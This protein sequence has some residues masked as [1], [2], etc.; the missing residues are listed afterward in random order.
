MSAAEMMTAPAEAPRAPS[1]RGLRHHWQVLRDSWALE[2]ERRRARVAWR[3][4]D[5][6]PAALEVTETPPNPLGRVLLWAL[7]ALTVGALTWSIVARLDVVA[8]AQGTVIAE[9]RNK[10]VQAQDAGVVGEILVR[11]GQR[12][13]RGQPLVTLDPTEAGADKAQAAASLQMAELDMA[14]SRAL[15]SAMN[16]E[17]WRFVP[18]PGTPE[19]MAETQRRLIDSRLAELTARVAALRRQADEA[20]ALEAGAT[21]EVARLTDTLPYLTERVERRRSLADKGHAS[22]LTQLE[23]EQQRVDHERQIVVQNQ[24]AA[25]A[26]A[27][28]AGT[29]EQITQAEA[30]A[31]REVLADQA[32]AEADARLAREELTKAEQRS[33]QQVIKAPADGVVQQLAVYAEGAVLKAAD[34]I[35]VVVPDD[36]TLI[37]EAQVLNKDIGFVAAGQAVT[38]KLEAFPFTRWGTLQGTLLWVSRD[39]VQDEKLGPVYVARVEVTPPPPG[40]GITISPGLAATAEINTGDRRVIDYFLSPLERR[41]DEA[42]RER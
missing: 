18:P 17:A 4:T 11:D 15:L 33:L 7:M 31:R 32:K 38:V 22:R 5:F 23:L 6:L 26:R 1:F 40:S 14:R 24:N 27:S 37:V 10:L 30:E 36:A 2:T 29:L 21:A 16:G 39:A 8:V 9:G 12:V 28:L 25:R 13:V 19:G 42:G 35:L 3:E 20:R 41:L 34:P